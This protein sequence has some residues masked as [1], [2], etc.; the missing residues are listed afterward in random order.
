MKTGSLLMILLLSFNAHA[1][2]GLAPLEQKLA[3]QNQGLQALKNEITSKERQRKSSYS[4]YY[5]TLEAVSGWGENRLDDPNENDK[6]YF[7]YADGKLNL[8]KGFKDVSVSNKKEVEVQIAKIEHEKKRR[9]LRHQLTEVA[10]EMIYLHRLQEI[11]LKEEEITKEQKKMAAKKVSSG[12]TSSVD[13]LEFDL[14]EEEL[15]IQKRQIDQLHLEAHNKL[16]QL[17]GN[18]VNDAELDKVAYEDFAT[19]SEVSNQSFENNPDVQKAQL[20][21]QLSEMEKKEVRSEFLPSLDFVY[22]FGRITPTEESQWDFNESQYALKLSIPLFSGFDT[23]Q[24]NKAAGADVLA[25][26]SQAQQVSFDSASTVKILK[27]KIKELSDLYKIN[28]RKLETSKKYFDMT[29][30]EYKRGIKN[31]PDLVGATERWFSS[32]KRK[33]EILKELELSKVKLENLY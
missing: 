29:V 2:K 13:N 7:G 12:L 16:I 22:S 9:E 3:E 21:S 25:K 27:D 6:G 11:L 8:F 10:S 15:R 14:R 32:Q 19:L 4:A 23:Y 24:K 5:P 17:F 33:Y 18:D 20:L 30:S 31:S 26:K 28:E 1:L